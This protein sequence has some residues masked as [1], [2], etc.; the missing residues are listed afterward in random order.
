MTTAYRDTSDSCCS[1]WLPQNERINGPIT[2]S[3]V[4]SG[5]SLPPD[6]FVRWEFCPWCGTSRRAAASGGEREA[7]N[8][9]WRVVEQVTMSDDAMRQLEGEA[10]QVRAALSSGERDGEVGA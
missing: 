8:H 9:I 5:T 7:F 3:Q 10:A 2:L 1:A 4:R 6:Y